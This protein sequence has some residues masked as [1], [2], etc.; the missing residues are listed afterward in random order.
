MSFRELFDKNQLKRLYNID[1]KEIKCQGNLSIA[2]YDLFHAKG[3]VAT[4]ILVTALDDA[5]ITNLQIKTN[6][7]A[8]KI[9]TLFLSDINS[10]LSTRFAINAEAIVSICDDRITIQADKSTVRLYQPLI[11]EEVNEQDPD[12]PVY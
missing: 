9:P 12:S 10:F 1:L 2:V 3:C 8:D 7:L 11:S 6:A 5:G 4:S